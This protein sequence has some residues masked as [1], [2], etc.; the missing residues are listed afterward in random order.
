MT[1]SRK[2]TLLAMGIIA[3]AIVVAL[4]F[5]DQSEFDVHTPLKLFQTIFIPCL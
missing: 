1:N 2:A 4:Y 3:L 5:S